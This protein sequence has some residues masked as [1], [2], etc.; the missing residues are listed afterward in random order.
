MATLPPSFETLL[1]PYQQ[2]V[3]FRAQLN[4]ARLSLNH[5]AATTPNF[6]PDAREWVNMSIGLLDRIDPQIQN[7]V[8]QLL[9][10]LQIQLQYAISTQG[11]LPLLEQ[12]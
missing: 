9:A 2:L 10:I 12:D 6:L 11:H 7:M 4:Q 5:L 3:A 1:E 8:S